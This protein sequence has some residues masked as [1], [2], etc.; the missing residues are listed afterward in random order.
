MTMHMTRID[1]RAR[2]AQTGN[3]QLKLTNLPKQHIPVY[4]LRPG[5]VRQK[6]TQ[7]P[8]KMRLDKLGKRSKRAKK[9]KKL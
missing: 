3:R 5:G 4:A 9:A 7:H 2:A 8:E 6:I 1:I